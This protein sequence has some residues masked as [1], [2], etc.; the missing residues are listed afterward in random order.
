MV[1]DPAI[2]S[3][4][5]TLKADTT[6]GASELVPSA[7]AVLRRAVRFDPAR[8]VDVARAMGEAQPSMA[9]FWHAALAALRDVEE[10]GAL[11]GFERRWRRAGAAMVRTAV[12]QLA[13][14][15]GR[16]LHVATCSFSGSVLAC[17]RA[18]GQRTALRVSCTEGRPALEGRRL[19]AAL[20][21]E[22]FAV[23]AFTDAGIGEALWCQSGRA[24]AVLVGAD[25]VS[26]GWMVNKAGSGMLAAAAGRVG[27]PVYVA[28]TRE[29][30]LD[31][32]VAGL[33]RIP[34]HG[35]AE[36]WNGAPPGV[37]VRNVYFERMPIDLVSGIITDAGTLSGDM[38]AEACRA[39]CA[40][41]A[42]RLVESLSPR[43]PSAP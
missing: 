5:E 35:P 29:K 31:A 15:R 6:S 24:D 37:A 20:A 25:A 36:V 41:I 19:A 17:L 13:P 34:E 28:A 42:D 43:R 9:S 2:A 27:V 21:G 14:D 32:R 18:L 8:L 40:G 10:P 1:M 33:L 26:P 39:A 38:I 23:V 4:I 7:I 11:E 22:G 16:P 12:D 30:F 3:A